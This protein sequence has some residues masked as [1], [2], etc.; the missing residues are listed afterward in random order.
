MD[1]DA[2]DLS[3]LP[4]GGWRLGLSSV[5]RLLDLAGAEVS[6]P[7][8]APFE[9]PARA[10]ALAATAATIPCLAD[11]S[12]ISA[13]P[14]RRVGLVAARDCRIYTG[15]DNFPS[16]LKPQLFHDRFQDRLR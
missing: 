6:E 5:G 13:F 10:T 7:T 11:I 9:Q 4:L 15:A 8:L 12:L 1:S 2:L 3:T 16:P 14:W